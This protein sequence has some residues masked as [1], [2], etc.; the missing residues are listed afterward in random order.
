[1]YT[2]QSYCRVIG[3]RMLT[4]LLRTS[5]LAFVEN[6]RNAPTLVRAPSYHSMMEVD[7]AKVARVSSSHSMQVLKYQSRPLV[8]ESAGH[9]RLPC[10]VKHIRQHPHRC[11]C[12]VRIYVRAGRLARDALYREKGLRRQAEA[13]LLSAEQLRE[14]E[15]PTVTYN[16]TVCAL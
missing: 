4:T 11:C 16:R 9:S 1:M 10:H 6:F 13:A 14:Q 8:S 15:V 12:C 7:F 3:R 2:L 5:L